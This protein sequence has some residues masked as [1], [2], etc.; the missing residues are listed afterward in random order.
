[1]PC[2]LYH[3][4]RC[5]AE[6]VDSDS[7]GVPRHPQRTVTDESGAEK[8]RCLKIR[9]SFG[10][11]ET[12]TGIGDRTLGEAAVDLV[13]GKACPFAEV[14]APGE[15]M[16]AGAAREAEP[17]HAHPCPA[18]KA[19]RPARKRHLGEHLTHDLVTWHDG[20]LRVGK[21][22]VDEV[23]VGPANGAGV[24]AQEHLTSVGRRVGSFGEL[25]RLAWFGQDEG[26]H[27]TNMRFVRGLRNEGAT[28]YAKRGARR[29]ARRV[30]PRP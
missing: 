4:V 11:G 18:R 6:S 15:A 7:L 1:M 5:C 12:V 25:E 13:T 2:H 30:G 21:L 8:R 16:F 22:A 17:G 14:L 26:A 24:H 9:I 20:Q 28:N 10:D 3:D 23:K 27:A 19:W 29:V